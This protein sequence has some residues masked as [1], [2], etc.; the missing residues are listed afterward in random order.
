MLAPESAGPPEG[1]VAAMDHVMNYIETEAPAHM[2]LVDWSNSRV[3]AAPRRR[4]I[5]VS[6]PRFRP[7]FAF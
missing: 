4:R 1:I 2:T 6:P 5:R 3:K 7:A